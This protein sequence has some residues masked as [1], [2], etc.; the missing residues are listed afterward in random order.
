MDAPYI[1]PQ[2]KEAA[3]KFFNVDESK[4][5]MTDTVIPKSN[6]NAVKQNSKAFAGF[7]AGGSGLK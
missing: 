4:S 3:F 5:A 1:P 7:T 6:M 2:D